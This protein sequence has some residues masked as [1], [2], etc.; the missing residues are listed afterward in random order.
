MKCC[1][2]L[3]FFNTVTKYLLR[4]QDIFDEVALSTIKISQG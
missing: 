3:T 2:A 1:V 4:Y